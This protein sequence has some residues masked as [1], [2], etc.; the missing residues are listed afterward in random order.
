MF[1]AVTT[2]ADCDSLLAGLFFAGVVECR[3]SVVEVAVLVKDAGEKKDWTVGAIGDPFPVSSQGVV[4]QHLIEIPVRP[5]V[6]GWF[7]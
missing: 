4:P 7:G 6:G 3:W 2:C 1:V 5:A